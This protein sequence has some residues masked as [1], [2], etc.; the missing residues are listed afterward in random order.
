M[1]EV[2]EYE[3]LLGK[4]SLQVGAKSSDI[5][6]A[7]RNAVKSYHPD[8]NPHAGQKEADMFISIT[9]IY[10]RLLELH[11]EREKRGGR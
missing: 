9:K 5:K 8:L 11:Q 1:R 4:F 2:S 7:Y 6:L 3:E 10:E